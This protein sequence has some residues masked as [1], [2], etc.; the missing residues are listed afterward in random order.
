[1]P[2]LRPCLVLMAVFTL[3]TGIAYPLLVTGAAQL[4]FP[5]QANGSL[6]VEHGQVVGSHLIGQPSDGPGWFWS[7]PSA[8]AYNAAGSGGANLAPVTE[9]QRQAWSDRAVALRASGIKGT[10]PSDAV[11]ASGSGLDPH[12]SPESALLQVPRIAAARGLDAERLQR[13]VT[14][15]TESPQLGLLG[16]PR[17]SVLELNLAL[18]RMSA[19]DR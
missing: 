16:A 10:L 1:M 4:V 19:G 2:L 15:R 7:R 3:L 9:P 18:T 14:E 13:L 5:D 8:V 11:T 12:L 6:V 17:V